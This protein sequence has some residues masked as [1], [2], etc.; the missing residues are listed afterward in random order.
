[1]IHL[2]PLIIIFREGK[3][4]TSQIGFH[5]WNALFAGDWNAPGA[6]ATTHCIICYTDG[7]EDFDEDNNSSDNDGDEE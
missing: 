3:D 1:M 5:I 2:I 6:D 7:D 4:R